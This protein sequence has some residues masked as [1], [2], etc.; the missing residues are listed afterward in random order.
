M[1]RIFRKPAGG[2]VG[3]GQGSSLKSFRHM[4][5]GFIAKPDAICRFAFPVIDFEFLL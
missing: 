5:S 4:S 1:F 2:A 3:V